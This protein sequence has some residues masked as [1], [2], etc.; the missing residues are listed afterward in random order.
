MT[1]LFPPSCFSSKTRQISFFSVCLHPIS[2]QQSP[3]GSRCPS[4]E[5]KVPKPTLPT[6]TFSCDTPTLHHSTGTTAKQHP[7]PRIPNANSPGS[8]SLPGGLTRLVDHF[9]QQERDQAGARALIVAG[10]LQ[11]G[12]REN[13]SEL[14]LKPHPRG[15]TPCLPICICRQAGA[16]VLQRIYLFKFTFLCCK[17]VG[18]ESLSKLSKQRFPRKVR[19]QRKKN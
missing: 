15:I 3:R 14:T 11:Q 5:I 17:K 1:F 13:P 4:P 2:I 19:G 6:A 12:N 9:Y 8:P 10:H 16:R 7:T 18:L